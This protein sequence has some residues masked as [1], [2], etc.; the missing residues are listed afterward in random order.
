M[1]LHSWIVQLV[2]RAAVN[3]DAFKESGVRVPLQEPQYRNI[4]GRR[5]GEFMEVSP[6]LKNF[7]SDNADLINNNEFDK[8]FDKA[9]GKLN[10]HDYEE[11]V[12]VIR[13]AGIDIL[14]YI[15]KIPAYYF[16]DSS[17]EEVT[18]PSKVI[19]IG[20]RAFA[21]CKN[22]RAVYLP[23]S[24]E[25][26]SSNAFSGCN[27]L[28]DVYYAGTKAQWRKVGV[29]GFNDAL[30]E[31]NIHCIDEDLTYTQISDTVYKLPD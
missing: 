23:D 21:D 4:L 11:F 9:E 28:K 30:Y 27:S 12:K 3:R 29:L 6:E 19:G 17:F 2:E 22:L 24:L 15:K 26:I 18:I 13:L 1:A 16:K 20:Y 31:S 5:K 8:L 10:V 7:I 14:P 25:V